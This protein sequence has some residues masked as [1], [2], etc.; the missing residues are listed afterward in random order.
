[1]AWGSHPEQE[2]RNQV[3]IFWPA[4]SGTDCQFS[5]DMSFGARSESATF[6]FAMQRR[7]PCFSDP[8]AASF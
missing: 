2:S 4:T 3:H 8:S 6:L 5:R 7:A 1:M